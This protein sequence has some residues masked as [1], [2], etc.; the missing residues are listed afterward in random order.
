MCVIVVCVDMDVWMSKEVVYLIIVVV[1]YI[2][3][4]EVCL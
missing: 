1:F 3:S 2:F 4:K